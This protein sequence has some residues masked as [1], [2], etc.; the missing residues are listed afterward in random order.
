MDSSRSRRRDPTDRPSVSVG[1]LP[2]RSNVDSQGSKRSV[3]AESREPT[4]RERDAHWSLVHRL[5]ITGDDLGRPA[6]EDAGALCSHE[7][8]RAVLRA[9]FT[10]DTPIGPEQRGRRRTVS[11]VDARSFGSQQGA[12]LE[13][14]FVEDGIGEAAVDRGVRSPVDGHDQTRSMSLIERRRYEVVSRSAGRSLDE[15]RPTGRSTTRSDPAEL[16]AN[17]SPSG[18]ADSFLGIFVRQRYLLEFPRV[19]RTHVIYEGELR[20]D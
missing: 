19:S 9:V 17:G 11:Q 8:R 20:R 4:A 12:R 2:I 15:R 18:G 13:R 3:N 1:V 5:R 10:R 7:S 16:T 6:S 14:A